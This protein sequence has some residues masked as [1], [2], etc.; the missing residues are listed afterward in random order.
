M[1]LWLLAATT[2]ADARP[3][4]DPDA[5]EAEL[6]RLEDDL[7]K[8]AQ[9]NSWSAVENIYSRMLELAP[10]GSPIDHLLGAQAALDQGEPLLAW[11]RLHR[12]TAPNAGDP[13]DLHRAYESSLELLESL[14]SRYGRV[15]IYVPSDK[16]PVMV[17]PHMPFAQEERDVITTAR[18]KLRTQRA[19][20]GLLPEG[21]YTIDGHRFEVRPE[22]SAWREIV[23]GDP[24]TADVEGA[25]PREPAESDTPGDGVTS[26]T[27]E[28]EPAAEGA[29]APGD[30]GQGMQ[31]AS[32]GSPAPEDGPG[33]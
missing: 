32:E 6:R 23:V 2:L 30:D 12:I 13:I 14:E 22:W 5:V 8:H 33:R 9:R 29:S 19:Y 15:A 18:E 24:S 1:L 11:Y 31:A 28:G 4:K 25:A 21:V 17:R 20:R 7:I 3:A 27:D 10:T 16:V 26:P